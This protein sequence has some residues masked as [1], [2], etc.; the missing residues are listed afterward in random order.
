ME[1]FEKKVKIPK[2]DIKKDCRSTWTLD[3]KMSSF[4]YLPYSFSKISCNI[5]I[6][7]K[8][9][10]IEVTNS[11]EVHY[12][13]KIKKQYE[14]NWEKSYWLQMLKHSIAVTYVI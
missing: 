9:N 2:G 1:I 7:N 4:L 13:M 5:N 6:K 11:S 8:I 3:I 14:E 10:V 12:F